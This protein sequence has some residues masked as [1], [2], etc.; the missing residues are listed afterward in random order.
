MTK[1]YLAHMYTDLR[2]T[3]KEIAVENGC[4]ISKV[5]SLLHKFDIKSNRNGAKRLS[6]EVKCSNCSG[7]IVRR[8]STVS[9]RNFCGYICYYGWMVGNTR[10]ENCNNWKGGITAISSNNLKTF[11]FRK[12]RRTVLKEFP[13]CIMCNNRTRLH[14]HHIKT[15][16]EFPELT[17]E[18]SNLVTLC[19]SCH[20]KV[21]GKEKEWEEYF[22][23][24]ICKGDE[25]LETPNVKTRAISIQAVEGLG[26]TEGSE[27]TKVSPNNNPSHECRPRKG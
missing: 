14:V 7:V 15:R 27:T 25:L 1:E 11:E 2:K 4:S 19:C 21:K 16:R 6:V 23:R 5:N 24:L 12:L 13:V 18:Q 20:A 3:C 26:S 22:M 10:G 9:K 17:F 8:P